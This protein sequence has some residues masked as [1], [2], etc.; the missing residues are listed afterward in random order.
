[1]G[2][3][4]GQSW[5]R[6]STAACPRPNC[7]SSPRAAPNTGRPHRQDQPDLP[8]HRPRALE[9]SWTPLSFKPSL[10]HIQNP[11]LPSTALVSA[12]TIALP[13]SPLGPLLGPPSWPQWS[14]PTQQADDAPKAPATE[15]SS[16]HSPTS[17]TVTSECHPGPPGPT[18]G[19]GPC[20]ALTPHLPL[21]PISPVG[22]P[23]GQL[24]SLHSPC[25]P[26]RPDRSLFCLSPAAA[27]CSVTVNW[28]RVSLHP[29]SV[30]SLAQSKQIFVKPTD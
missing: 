22:L 21:P 17:L 18:R 4:R 2:R 1:M 5:P 26:L 11:T 29:H 19:K 12:A 14:R 8:L 16:T 23:R 9:P 24:L 27:G 30:P 20:W 7:C 13:R 3:G 10:R 15:P 25:C 28:D 6:I